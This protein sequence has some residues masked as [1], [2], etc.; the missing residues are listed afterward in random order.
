MKNTGNIRREWNGIAKGKF[1][2]KY[3]L[4]RKMLRELILSLRLQY[5]LNKT[6]WPLQVEYNEEHS[7]SFL[8][9]QLFRK[10]TGRYHSM[11][12]VE[13]YIKGTCNRVLI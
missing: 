4:L 10:R 11:K 2:M 6:E 7:G 12:Q 8:R 5:V 13:E 9:Y 1:Y 3:S